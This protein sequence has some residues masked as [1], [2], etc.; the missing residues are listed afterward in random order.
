MDQISVALIHKALDGLSMRAVATAENV[1]NVGTEG[2]RPWIVSFET[3]LKSA[4]QGTLADIGNVRPG[5]ARAPAAAFGE[6]L[7]VDMELATA[8]ETALRYSALLDVLGR[9]M[10]ISRA[11]VMG[12]Q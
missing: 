2:Y 12:G 7:R 1:A 5:M 9:Q 10:Q 3:A 11:S 8:S 6:Q 4:A